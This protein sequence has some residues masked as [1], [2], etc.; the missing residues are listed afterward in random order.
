L[1]F[2]GRKEKEGREARMYGGKEGKGKEEGKF[3]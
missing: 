2:L 3:G 1:R